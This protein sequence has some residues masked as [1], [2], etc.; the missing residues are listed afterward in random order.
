MYVRY[1]FPSIL[2]IDSLHPIIV[3]ASAS[4][5]S[6]TPSRGLLPM[7]PCVWLCLWLCLW[8][9]AGR[10]GISAD[11]F[12]MTPN[13]QAGCVVIRPSCSVFST[14]NDQN[15]D[16]GNGSERKDDW[17]K[18]GR[19]SVEVRKTVSFPASCFSK[20][21]DPLDAASDCV[22]DAWMEYHWRKG[23]GL[24]IVVILEKQD[25]REDTN[26]TTG[27][28]LGIS[29]AHDSSKKRVIA[30][31]MMEETIS[32]FPLLQAEK[33]DGSDSYGGSD[34]ASLELEYKVTSPGPFFGPDLVQGSHTGRV[35]FVSSYVSASN[36]D[37]SNDNDDDDDA[38]AITTTLVWKV[39]FDAIRLLNLYQKVTEFTI[40]TA[41][42]TVQ[43]AV[44]TPRLFTLR[45]RLQMPN[46]G[47]D[48]DANDDDDDDNPAHTARQEWL[49]FL[50]STTG[51]GLP[52]PPP[53]PFGDVLPEG[54]GMARKKIFRFPPGLIETA[55]VE[56]PSTAQSAAVATAAS[57]K[58][59][60]DGTATAC[61]QLEN[62]GWWT[63][64]F[65]VHTHLGR[66]RF[67]Q[68]LP[69]VTQEEGTTKGLVVDLTWE[70]EIRPYPFTA[71]LV[72][73]LVELTVSTIAR[74]LRVK[75]EDPGAAVAI[76]LP[77]GGSGQKQQQLG[78]VPRAT[79]V[80]CVLEVHESDTRSSWE[81]SVSLLKPWAWDDSGTGRRG[82]DD[83]EFEWSDG[84]ME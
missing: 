54:G 74:N 47:D 80:G 79:W 76:R 12:L 78:S 7:L 64:P 45:T 16:S 20:G 31:V 9:L 67:R 36:D 66:A 6:M 55:M 41:A 57:K 71:P 27:G 49:D 22:R 30:P 48:D 81:Q 32:S 53:L 21:N 52:L 69:T 43:E 56:G 3:V 23:G 28:R 61:Y 1:G 83:I 35:A 19:V 63:L 14:S 38:K 33:S 18:G 34:A 68:A 10:F 44:S 70:V 82:E 84:G 25:K 60:G 51:G 5:V 8:S 46:G 72:E 26:D 40:G 77:R 65:L 58:N 13:H 75:L 73:K 15:N 11:A 17:T 24:P 2:Q 39:E 37:S 62:P 42:T 4:L 59:D 50:F 29:N